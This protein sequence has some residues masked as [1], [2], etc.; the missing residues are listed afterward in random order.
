MSKDNST[1]ILQDDRPLK[2]DIERILIVEVLVE[3]SPNVFS[4]FVFKDDTLNISV[5]DQYVMNEV[6]YSYLRDDEKVFWNHDTLDF[7]K[8]ELNPFLTA[9]ENLLYFI[10]TNASFQN[11]C[12]ITFNPSN[13]ASQILIHDLISI[14]N[15]KPDN[16]IFV[17]HNP[18]LLTMLQDNLNFIDLHRYVFE[19]SLYVFVCTVLHLYYFTF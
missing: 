5:H 9:T 11:S 15:Q 19:Y 2:Q 14:T 16:M 12:W 10:K 7:D 4:K 17:G 6:T 8:N 18:I 3:T 13:F 1:F